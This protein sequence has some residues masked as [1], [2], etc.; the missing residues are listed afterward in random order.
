MQVS[1]KRWWR[2]LLS[3]GKKRLRAYQYICEALDCS[4]CDADAAKTEELLKLMRGKDSEDA[5]ILLLPCASEACHFASNSCVAVSSRF[6][7]CN[8]YFSD[9]YSDLSDIG[10]VP[11]WKGGLTH[12]LE[13]AASTYVMIMLPFKKGGV[14]NP[15]GETNAK[16]IRHVIKGL[17]QIIRSSFGSS[18][19][20]VPFLVSVFQKKT[21]G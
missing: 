18:R 5:R 3:S 6:A 7:K 15:L 1:K 8:E 17:E 21:R 16:R 11:F 9:M 4:S 20:R 2:A 14:Q 12:S 10:A 13:H 19:W